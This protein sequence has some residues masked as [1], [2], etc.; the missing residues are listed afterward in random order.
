VSKSAGQELGIES[1][2]HDSGPERVDL[3]RFGAASR[4][5]ATS[6]AGDRDATHAAWHILI[7]ALAIAVVAATLAGLLVLSRQVAKQRAFDE[8]VFNDVLSVLK[9]LDKLEDGTVLDLTIRGPGTVPGLPGSF[10][11]EG[12][13]L[14][15]RRS[16][17][18]ETY[19]RGAHDHGS[20]AYRFH[21]GSLYAAEE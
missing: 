15:V 21:D 7:R 1:V 16:P 10:V 4:A 2:L 3:A 5:D 9:A 6:V 17:K 8:V 19:V 14:H 12:S 20:L 18:G 11:S 13:T